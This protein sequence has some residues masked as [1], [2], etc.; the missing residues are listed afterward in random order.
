MTSS[1]SH[2]AMMS[3]LTLLWPVLFPRDSGSTRSCKGNMKTGNFL[4]F[5]DKNGDSADHWTLIAWKYRH[6][7]CEVQ[8]ISQDW[9]TKATETT[10]TE[11]AAQLG[12]GNRKCEVF[13]L[14]RQWGWEL[15]PTGS[16]SPPT[17][18]PF[19]SRYTPQTVPDLRVLRHY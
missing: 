19:N 11:T 5:Y 15:S 2:C 17:L 14:I 1:W 9:P 4:H 3:R 8:K 16:L 12:T 7:R 10:T 18:W 13:W 6:F